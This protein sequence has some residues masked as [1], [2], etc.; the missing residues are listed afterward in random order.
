MAARRIRLGLTPDERADLISD[1][2][3]YCRS[4]GHRWM[5]K[6][7]SE[8]RLRETLRNGI[9]ENDRFCDNGCGSEW[10]EL[11]DAST[12]ETVQT[13]RHYSAN[14]LLKPNSG[15]LPRTE[16]RKSRFVRQFP[17]FA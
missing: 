6:P 10:F 17:Q 16:A 5:V 4:Y 14:Y 3:L 12:F 9:I 1:E 2:A 13:K 8:A 15:R 7:M 11:L